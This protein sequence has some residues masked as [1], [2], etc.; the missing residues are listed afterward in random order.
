MQEYVNVDCNRIISVAGLV[1]E[2]AQEHIIAE[3]RMVKHLD[4]PYADLAFVVDEQYQG[5]GIATYLYEML[6]R[7][8]KERGIRGFTADV[9]ASNKGMMK[10]FEKGDLP[11]KA[12][13]EEGAFALTIPFDE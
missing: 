4:R 12:K 10:V 13:L 11:V 8:A 6:T 2:P 7:L 9:L 5:L 3:A 1:G